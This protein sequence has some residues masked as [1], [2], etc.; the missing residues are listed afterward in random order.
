MYINAVFAI[1]R[2]AAPGQP[3]LLK[4]SKVSY[5]QINVSWE[6]P[7]SDGGLPIEG[8]QL[9]YSTESGPPVVLN[10][11]HTTFTVLSHLLPRTKYTIKVKAVH[12]ID[13]SNYTE[14]SRATD[15]RSKC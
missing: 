4:F 15:K 12:S 5:N 11:T 10:V 7:D 14:K 8:Y 6:E 3:K 9:Q 1:L 2:L 13:G